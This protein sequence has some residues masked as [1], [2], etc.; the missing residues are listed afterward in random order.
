MGISTSSLKRV[1]GKIELQNTVLKMSMF[2]DLTFKLTSS[3]AVTVAQCGLTHLGSGAPLSYHKRDLLIIFIHLRPYLTQQTLYR[4]ASLSTDRQ[5][6]TR[7][8]Q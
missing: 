3:V 5:N 4:R 8:K 2:W 7:L 1:V 6:R